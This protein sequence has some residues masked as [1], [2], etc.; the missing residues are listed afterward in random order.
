MA[1]WLRA[2]TALPEVLNSI[3]SNHMVA[4]NHLYWDSM[5]SSGVHEDSNSVLI[6]KTKQN[7]TKPKKKNPKKPQTPKTYI[8]K[9]FPNGCLDFVNSHFY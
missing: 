9:V 2:L 6:H 4:Y 3:S 1:Q 7:K 8:F 5:F